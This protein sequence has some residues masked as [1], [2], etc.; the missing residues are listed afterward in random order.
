MIL[1]WVAPVREEV[2]NQRFWLLVPSGPL[3]P[4]KVNLVHKDI[5]LG[6]KP[7]WD[8]RCCKC[9]VNFLRRFEPIIVL[10][11]PATRASGDEPHPV[12]REPADD[13]TG[14]H[15]KLIL[16]PAD[17]GQEPRKGPS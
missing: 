4:I 11:T 8:F 5:C 10:D 2:P 14:H 7:A 3:D 13:Q 17:G 12:R 15:T 16:L 1:T 6:I 9:L